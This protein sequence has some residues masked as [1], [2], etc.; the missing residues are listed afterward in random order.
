MQQ[1]RMYKN[2]NN[3]LRVRE[4]VCMWRSF[5]RCVENKVRIHRSFS[6]EYSYQYAFGEHISANRAWE[7]SP[8]V[9]FYS[10]SFSFRLFLDTNE[11]RNSA[12][13]TKSFFSTWRNEVVL[14]SHE[15]AKIFIQK[16]KAWLIQRI[17]QH[18]RDWYTW[19][20][21]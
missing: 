10:S 13:T 12:T 16:Q 6:F 19:M 5:S 20:K 9:S 1:H 21:R 3:V 7:F 17:Q 8:Y 11:E 4:S 18:Y 2:K 15:F 14:W